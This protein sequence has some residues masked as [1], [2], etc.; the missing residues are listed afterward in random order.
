MIGFKTVAVAALSSL[1]LATPAIQ[2]RDGNIVNHGS[3][4]GGGSSGGGGP[5]PSNVD[6]RSKIKNVVV[7]VEENRSFD[8]FA[9][10]L[11]YNG[12]I[13]GLLHHNYCNSL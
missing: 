9:G 3:S 8:T 12:A 4:N 6:W 11:T 2:N 5:G 10:G 7:L 13:D 1:V